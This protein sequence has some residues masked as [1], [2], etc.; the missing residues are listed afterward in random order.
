MA[1]LQAGVYAPELRGVTYDGRGVS[2]GALLEEGRKVWVVFY[3]YATC[4]LCN[5][6]IYEVD[7]RYDELRSSGIEVLA[8]FSSPPAHFSPAENRGAPRV[9]MVADP[10]RVLYDA[11][12]VE[13]SPWKAL[14]ISV[15][16]KLMLARL[17]GF[18]RPGPKGKLGET[19]AHFLV[20][21]SGKIH[22]AYYGRTIADQLGWWEVRKFAALRP[23]GDGDGG[24]GPGSATAKHLDWSE[25]HGIN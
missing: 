14:R 19:P 17:R 9:P 12:G 3:R 8:I 5:E 1:R 11:Y 18:G 24:L 16:F 20:L 25:K 15:F 21:P 6:H 7:R 23:G 4:P 10:Q 2:L 22:L 13:T